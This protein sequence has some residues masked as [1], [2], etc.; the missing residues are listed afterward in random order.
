[1]RRDLV[2]ALLV[3]VLLHAGLAF[4]FNRKPV[5]PAPPLP[6]PTIEII[7]VPPLEPD[8]PLPANTSDEPPADPAAAPPTQADLPSVQLD[9]PFVQPIQPSLPSDLTRPSG[10]ITIPAGRVGS[11]NGGGFDKIFNLADLDEPP[12]AILQI[13][14]VY[15]YELLRAGI[16]GEVTLELTID[17]QGNV[18]DVII[19]SSSH[20]EFEENA[21]QALLRWKF[22]PGKLGGRAVSVRRTQL[23][24]FNIGD[25]N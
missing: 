22:K 23:F 15:P 14:P 2:I 4:G 21:R 16:A 1:M 17:P 12:A 5:P 19:L 20:R 9:T 18:R 13:K 8:E 10:L 6:P 24:S 25:N 11:G 3:S 7:A